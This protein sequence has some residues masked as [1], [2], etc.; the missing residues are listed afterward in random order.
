[1]LD[2]VI[3]GGLVVDGTGA[4]ARWSDVGVRDGRVVEI[5]TQV[6]AAVRTID[7]EGLTVAPGFVDIHTHYDAQLLWDPLASPSLAHGVTSVIGRNCGVTL[8]P[9]REGDGEYLS[10]LMVRVEGVPLAALDAALDWSWSIRAIG[11]SG[12]GIAVNAGVLV[13]HSSLRRAVMGSADGGPAREANV[14]A[15]VGLL[16]E[17]LDAGGL[18]L[19][20]SLPP[21]Q[22][23]GDG[24]PVRA[25]WCRQA[26]KSTTRPG[27]CGLRRGRIL[28]RCSAA[29]TRVRISTCSA[30]PAMR[31]HLLGDSV[32]KRGLVSLEAAVHQLTDVPARLY[33][34]VGR[35]HIAEGWWADLVVLDLTEV[36]S[37]RAH[38][39]RDLRGGAERLVADASG[40]AAVVVNGRLVMCEGGPTGNLSSRLL[41]SGADTVTVGLG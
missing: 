35:G 36:G 22:N 41:R 34:L 27:A 6:G 30:A 7:A 25:A 8:A 1:M 37:G 17:A 15:M 10:R 33:G 19:S 38:T 20:T 2:L 5:S 24:C 11:L 21:T 18:G 31:R 13:G 16:H 32:R 28:G 14:T 39:V 26:K 9:L 3:R 12:A 4:K 40:I 23:D 29:P